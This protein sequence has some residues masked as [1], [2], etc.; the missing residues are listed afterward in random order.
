MG[1]PQAPDGAEHYRVQI[2]DDGSGSDGGA[3][4]GGGTP[5]APVPFWRRTNLALVAA[6]VLVGAFLAVGLWWL[7]SS[8]PMPRMYYDPAGT[9]QLIET[10]SQ[11]AMNLYGIGALLLLLGIMGAF[12]LLLVQ[13]ARFRRRP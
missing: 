9:N 2:V 7:T 13:S 8:Y 10:S 3:V 5:S 4:R 1:N 11:I 6:W 12:T